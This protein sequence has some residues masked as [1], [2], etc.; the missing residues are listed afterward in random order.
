MPIGGIALLGKRGGS[1]GV[2]ANPDGAVHVEV[3]AEFY[4][5]HKIW[6]LLNG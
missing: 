2:D 4:P 6:V 3:K 1:A 5:I